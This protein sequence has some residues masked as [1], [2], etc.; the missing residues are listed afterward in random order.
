MLASRANTGRAVADSRW[1][2]RRH[3]ILM[4]WWGLSR[5]E[6]EDESDLTR[7]VK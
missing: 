3:T 6:T 4:G 5:D 7:E 1:M 2:G